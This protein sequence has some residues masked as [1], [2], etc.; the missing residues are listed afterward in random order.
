MLEGNEK[1]EDLT[2]KERGVMT[3]KHVDKGSEILRIPEAL[4]LN[5]VPSRPS[6]MLSIA[7]PGRA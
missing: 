7:I 2:R 1:F 3:Q 4:L 5:E 6:V